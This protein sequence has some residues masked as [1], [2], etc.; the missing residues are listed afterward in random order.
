[1]L[2]HSKYHPQLVHKVSL[3]YEKSEK[4][5]MT[6]ESLVKLVGAQLEFKLGLQ[7]VECKKL[8][9]FFPLNEG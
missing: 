2:G 4:P 9:L 7:V 8:L 1:M 6:L 3:L 5:T